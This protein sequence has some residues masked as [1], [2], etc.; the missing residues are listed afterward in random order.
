MSSSSPR[1]R[2]P[3]RFRLSLLEEEVQSQRELIRSLTDSMSM[4]NENMSKM[5]ANMRKITDNMEL[6]VA[7]QQALADDRPHVPLKRSQQ[8][9]TA[10]RVSKKK[11]TK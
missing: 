9:G 3:T 4:M 8:A 5:A 6:M 2:T 1:H 10:A 7:V 11:R